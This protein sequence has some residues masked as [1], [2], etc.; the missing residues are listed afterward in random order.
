MA[1]EYAEP[2]D[3]DLDIDVDGLTLTAVVVTGREV[4]LR[5]TGGFGSFIDTKGEIANFEPGD[6]VQELEELEG[7]LYCPYASDETFNYMVDLLM[8]WR[9]RAV[10]LRM[11]GA[12]D[13]MFSLI[14]N[15][16]VWIPLPRREHEAWL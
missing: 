4:L 7:R 3:P 5:A 6:P 14:E 1:K 10:P 9:D 16:E 11:C 15:R 13:R 8:Q 12:P 2:G